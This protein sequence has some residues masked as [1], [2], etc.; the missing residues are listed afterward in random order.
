[1]GRVGIFIYVV[2]VN[3]AQVYNLTTQVVFYLSASLF[4]IVQVFMCI[5]CL[6]DLDFCIVIGVIKT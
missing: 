6:Q 1:M 2:S 3:A 5:I 4:I